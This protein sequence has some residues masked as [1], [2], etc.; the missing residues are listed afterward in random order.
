MALEHS[1]VILLI[2]LSFMLLCFPK[3]RWKFKEAWKIIKKGFKN[4]DGG[5][6]KRN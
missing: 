5:C 2:L 3:Q 4:H 6:E 1:S